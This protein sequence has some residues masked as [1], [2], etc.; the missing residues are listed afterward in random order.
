[1]AVRSSSVRFSHFSLM[2]RKT[3]AQ[4]SGGLLFAYPCHL[5]AAAS[6]SRC[7][8]ASRYCCP[9]WAFSSLD[10]GRLLHAGGPFLSRCRE[11]SAGNNAASGRLTDC[12]LPTTVRNDEDEDSR[13]CS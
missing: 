2:C 12:S 8:S 5:C 11:Q 7:G 10:L 9:P 13:N 1:M 4:D 6:L 3:V